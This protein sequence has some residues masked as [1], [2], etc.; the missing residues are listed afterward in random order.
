[1]TPSASSSPPPA[2][3]PAARIEALRARGVRILD[4]G[5]TFVDEDVDP[6]RIHSTAVLYPGTRLHG[7]GTFLAAGAVVGLEGPATLA[8]CV[9]GEGAS[10]ASGYAKG[11]VL[12]RGAKLGA[13]CHC[14][15][16]TILEEEASTAHAVGLKQ[17]VLLPFVTLGSL[18]NFC[19]LLMAGGTSREDHSEVGSGFIHF[20][21]TPWGR[22]GDKATPSLVG[23]VTSGVFLRQRRIFLGGLSGM[24]GPRAVGFGSMTGAGQIVRRDVGQ[25]RLA[26]QV[27][28]PVDE[29]LERPLD[30]RV[31]PVID[32]N[33]EYIAQLKALEAFYV[34]ARLG[35]AR[36]AGQTDLGI[37]YEAAIANVGACIAERMS[38]LKS[39]LREHGG[40]A[41]PELG[42]VAIPPCPLP[43]DA[44]PP[45][46]DHIKWVRGLGDADVERGQL[47]LQVIADTTRAKLA[48]AAV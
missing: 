43:L 47:W 14:R 42:A 22:A 41:L 32:K 45:D 18:I 11:T 48:V 20:N 17:T 30:G 40:P 2:S 4:P 19:D 25:R 46:A 16:G 26:I 5:Q 15:E 3:T 31:Q 33:V 8:D 9:L 27:A 1:M 38:R 21:F 6:A 44:G 10:I 34:E 23:D 13:N 29:P 39:F 36:R 24:V 37:I 28:R 12:L 35:R 7:R